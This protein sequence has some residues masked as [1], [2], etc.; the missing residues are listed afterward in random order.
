MLSY[1]SINRIDTQTTDRFVYNFNIYCLGFYQETV[2]DDNNN[3]FCL[4]LYIIFN[5]FIV[6][7]LI[8]NYCW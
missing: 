7:Y 4:K 6:F 3:Y 8:N 2:M 5:S 1:S